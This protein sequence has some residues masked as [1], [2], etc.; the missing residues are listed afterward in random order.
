MRTV[1]IDL[2]DQLK[3][4]ENLGIELIQGF[5]YARPMTES[6]FVNAVRAMNMKKG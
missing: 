6:E 2:L 1:P 4:M 3:M 5:Y